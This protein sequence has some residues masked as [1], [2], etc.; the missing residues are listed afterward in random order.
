MVQREL[1]CRRCVAPLRVEDVDVLR[2]AGICPRCGDLVRGNAVREVDYRSLAPLPRGDENDASSLAPPPSHDHRGSS[3]SLSWWSEMPLLDGGV[4]VR[5]TSDSHALVPKLF[6]GLIFLLLGA[7]LTAAL[8]GA[9]DAAPPP[10][11]VLLGLGSAV[12]GGLTLGRGIWRLGQTA[13]FSFRG[14]EVLYAAGA[15]GRTL[16]TD[17][18]LRFRPRI[19][20]MG[21]ATT[22]ETERMY[23][24]E[25][26]TRSEV[27]VVPLVLT[28][29]QRVHALAARLDSL[30]RTAQASAFPRPRDASSHPP[31]PSPPL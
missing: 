12:F 23:T 21:A 26:V 11:L 2:D 16:A 4:S 8:L 13:T 3:R 10:F 1:T 28:G 15:A 24:V 6:A 17:D 9:R 30:L 31:A 29:E 25:I 18:V 20:G 27:V 7:G 22:R 5:V 14:A 19:T